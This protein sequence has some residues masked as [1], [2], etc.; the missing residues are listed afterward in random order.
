MF[1][2]QGKNYKRGGVVGGKAYTLKVNKPAFQSQQIEN[3]NVL[4][5]IY[6]MTEHDLG[7]VAM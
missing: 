2:R 7:K 1:Q 5:K 4:S 6:V 3:I